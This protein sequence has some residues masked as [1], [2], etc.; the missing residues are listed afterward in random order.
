MITAREIKSLRER[1]GISIAECKRA[2]EA[3]GGDE[4]KAIAWLK[5][6]GKQVAGKKSSRTLGAGTVSAYIHSTGTLGALFE[7][8]SETD[9]VAKNK[10]FRS[11]ADDLAMHIAAMAPGELSEFLSQPF[12]KDPSQ[13]VADVID[14]AVQKFGE[15]VEVG[16]WHRLDARPDA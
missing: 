14:A 6:A 8:R 10:D 12:V 11:L 16:S 7:L 13:T 2:L 9:F 1:T 15:R 4:D 3:G 5:T